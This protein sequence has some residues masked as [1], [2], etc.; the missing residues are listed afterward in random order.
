M[1]WMM[2]N[3]EQHSHSNKQEKGQALC[4]PLFLCFKAS[5]PP[6][7]PLKYRGVV[8]FGYPLATQQK[9]NG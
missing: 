6:I 2:N 4:K 9:K 3:T 1:V 7:I 5:P 8:A